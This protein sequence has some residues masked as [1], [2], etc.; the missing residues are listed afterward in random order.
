MRL[1]PVLQWDYLFTTVVILGLTFGIGLLMN[2]FV[3]API[4]DYAMEINQGL[5]KFGPAAFF[6]VFVLLLPLIEEFI[7][8]TVTVNVAEQLSLPMWIT[9]FISA[10]S[11]MIFKII[12]VGSPVLHLCLGFILFSLYIKH[13]SLVTN[14]F[15]SSL[16]NA[17][18]LL[19]LFMFNQ[20]PIPNF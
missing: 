5:E 1:K 6:A 9:A 18:T 12:A 4:T 3:D 15:Y 13:R 17:L 20:L 11:T 14:V 8:R 2:N 10:I 7:C 19:V 16:F